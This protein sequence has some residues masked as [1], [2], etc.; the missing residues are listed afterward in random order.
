MVSRG[1]EVLGVDSNAERVQQWADRL[2]HVL[3]V[4]T[5][6]EVALRQVGAQEFDQAVVAIGSDIESSVLTTTILADCGILADTTCREAIDRCE[7]GG[8]EL[9]DRLGRGSPEHRLVLSRTQS[10]SS[11]RHPG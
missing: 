8:E 10:E 9:L 11:R 7:V 6:D 4:D 3:Q 5:T 1:R 2:T